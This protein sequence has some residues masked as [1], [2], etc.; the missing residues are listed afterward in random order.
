MHKGE[1]DRMGSKFELILLP[2]IGLFMIFFIQFFERHPELHNYPQRL[3]ESNA[4][5]ILFTKPKISKSVE[6]YLS[7]HFYAF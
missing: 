4:R 1:V 5:T 2:G 7:N 3:N 6:K